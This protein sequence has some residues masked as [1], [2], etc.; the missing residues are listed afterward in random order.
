MV[1]AAN[2]ILNV[3]WLCVLQKSQYILFNQPNVAEMVF[4][5]KSIH[6]D[7]TQLLSNINR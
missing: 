2:R 4:L 7:F 5:I 3:A 6:V 1:H